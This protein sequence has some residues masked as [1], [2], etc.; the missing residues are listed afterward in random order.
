MYTHTFEIKIDGI[1]VEGEVSFDTG[2]PPK[3]KF[4]EGF[5]TTF[6]EMRHIVEILEHFRRT[7]DDCGIIDRVEII[8]K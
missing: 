5:E 8:K 6:V 7:C 2:Q 4:N 3:I 1:D